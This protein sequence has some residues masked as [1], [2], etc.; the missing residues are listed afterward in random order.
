MRRTRGLLRLEEKVAAEGRRL[1]RLGGPSMRWVGPLA[2]LAACCVHGAVLLLPAARLPAAPPAASPVRDFPRV[3]RVAPPELP[4]PTPPAARPAPAA[5]EP[6]P[7]DVRSAAPPALTRGFST[8]PVPEPPPDLVLSMVSANVEPIIPNPDP[9]P[10]VAEFGPPATGPAPTAAPPPAPG[11]PELVT[12][13]PPVYPP[14]ARTIRAEGRV[15]LRLSVLP[16]GSVGGATV[17]ECTR[18]GLGFEAAAL[19]AVKRWRYEPS[20]QQAGARKVVVSVHFQQQ[21][22]RP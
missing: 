17:E 22:A 15:T 5:R 14:A 12:S 20:P 1:D 9:S 6:L 13:V 3:W 2:F 4:Q 21:E 16:D 19:E 18:K 10:A 11:Q 7:P 8:E